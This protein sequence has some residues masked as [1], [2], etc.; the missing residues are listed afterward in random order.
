MF[1]MWKEIISKGV[2][3]LFF[4]QIVLMEEEPVVNLSVFSLFFLFISSNEILSLPASWFKQKMG[5]RIYHVYNN[6]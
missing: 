2:L 3:C 5:N 6:M 4:G 1:N